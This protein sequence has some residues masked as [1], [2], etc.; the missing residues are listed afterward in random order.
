MKKIIS[1]LLSILMLLSMSAG[2]DFSAFADEQDAST[3]VAADTATPDKPTVTYSYDE[4]SATLTISGKGEMKLKED[5]GEMPWK[6]Y[7]NS[8]LNL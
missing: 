7:A 4:E 3:P 5:N 2:L 1:L 6:S 8:I